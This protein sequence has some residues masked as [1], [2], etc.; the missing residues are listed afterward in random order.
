MTRQQYGLST[1]LQTIGSLLIL[2][3]DIVQ[4]RLQRSDR[5]RVKMTVKNLW[6]ESCVIIEQ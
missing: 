6:L 5:W 1:I 2:F 4:S 3:F